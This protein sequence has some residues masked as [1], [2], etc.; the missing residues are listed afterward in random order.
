MVDV[1][2]L[3]AV[4]AGLD[5]AQ[6]AQQNQDEILQVFNEVNRQLSAGFDGRL[7]IKSIAKIE[8]MGLAGAAAK[9]IL[10]ATGNANVEKIQVPQCLVAYNPNTPERAFVLAEWDWGE[11]GYPCSIQADQVRTRCDNAEELAQALQTLL[12]STSAGKKIHQ[13][14]FEPQAA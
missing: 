10:K 8:Q 14:L 1:D 3:S 5:S 4:K 7:Q 11:H 6:M 9:A 2:F 13:L 12:Q